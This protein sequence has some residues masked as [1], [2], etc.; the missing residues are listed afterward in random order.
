MCLV[1]LTYPE[2]SVDVARNEGW[3]R[4]I[5][6]MYSLNDLLQ[7]K[8]VYHLSRPWIANWETVLVVV[9]EYAQSRLTK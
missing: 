6:C 4:K 2:A 3:E 9:P 7:K 5:A 8:A 1:F